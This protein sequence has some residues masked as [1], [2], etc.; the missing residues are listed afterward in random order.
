MMISSKNTD[1]NL[2]DA[3]K[4]L[5]LYANKGYDLSNN[6][7]KLLKNKIQ[8]VSSEIENNIF[9]LEHSNIND[10]GVSKKLVNQLK[11]IKNNFLQLPYQ[12]ENN[13]KILSKQQFSITLFGRTMTGK[14]TMMEILTH[15]NGSSIG[16]G[17][18][19][20]TRNVRTYIYKNM[21]VIDV[22]GIAAFEGTDDEMVAFNAAKKSDL[23]LFLLTDDAPQASEAEC[24]KKI[25]DLGKPVI[26]IINVKIDID[27]NTSFKLFV[28]D[29]KKKLK[30]E[31]LDAIKNQL[32]DFGNHY[33]QNWSNLRFVYVHLKSAYLAQQPEWKAYNEELQRISRFNYLEKVIAEEVISNGRFYKLKS[34]MDVIIVPVT[35]LFEVLCNQSSENS[36]Q[37]S[38]LVKKRRKLI[39][40]TDDFRNDSQR[41]IDI[42]VK[43]LIGELKQEVPLFAEENYDNSKADIKWKA[44]LDQYDIESRVTELLKELANKCD[45][46]LQEICRE[47]NF[48]LNFSHIN[49]KDKS[50]KMPFI[51]DSKR[52]WEWATTLTSN[53][54]IITGL[55]VSGPIGWI[56]LGVGFIGWLGSFLFSNKEKKVHDAR[57]KLENKLFS[58]LE[59]MSK[60]LI[61]YMNNI[62][63]DELINKRLKTT[64]FTLD[65]TINSVFTLSDI[66]LNF[67]KSLNKKLMQMNKMVVIQ[68]LEYN[69]YEGLDNYISNIVRIPG[70]AM[71]VLL[72][73]GERFPDDARKDLSCLL[74]ESVWF[75][76][77]RNNLKS[78]LTQAIGKGCQKDD[79]KIQYIDNHPRIAHI[80]TLDELDCKTLIR[81]RLAQQ[82]TEL[83]IME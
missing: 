75:V 22:P 79:I 46:E 72:E 19:R 66:Q 47:I 39:K 76:F 82:L 55:F 37:G 9:S 53:G 65:K 38:I 33:G 73:N 2:D 18:Q 41:R 24:L 17:A 45:T 35:N 7:I 21:K 54:L 26:C 32:V 63:N 31:R 3:L 49:F 44:V 4:E 57:R 1:Y 81:V 8:I 29:I 12:L 83:L 27:K 23:I 28:R 78:I 30:L 14:S 40:W 6:T 15:G 34:F 13:L 20:A 25:L 36:L 64:I 51:I 56:G 58:Y 80:L 11:I 43:S 69:G 60:K 62:L 5:Q 61:I 71:I 70:N 42:F 50:I 74:N 68:A 10:F 77:N 67:L 16:K 48:E 59:D 52:I